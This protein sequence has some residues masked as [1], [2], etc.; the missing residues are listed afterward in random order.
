M[1]SYIAIGSNLGDKFE[2]CRRAVTAL[3]REETNRI[4]RCSSF[5]R[6]EPVGRKDQDWFLNGVLAVETSLR[7]RTLLEF[8]LGVEKELGRERRER[9]GPRLIDLDIL[10]YGAEVINERAL[11]IPHPRIPERRFVLVPLNEIAPGLVHPL[12]RRT[13]GEMLSNLKEGD[14]VLPLPEEESRSLCFA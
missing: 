4:V 13:V 12:L 9:W 8:L 10:F 6:T 11:E 14:R 2:N 3:A 7:P 1:L 5:Y